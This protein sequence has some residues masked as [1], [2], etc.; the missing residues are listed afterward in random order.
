MSIN[1]VG[2]LG[3]T[4]E[5][6]VSQFYPD[7]RFPWFGS[8]RRSISGIGGHTTSNQISWNY[9]KILFSNKVNL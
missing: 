1:W 2:K 5:L 3:Q 9:P 7:I 8:M 4:D 6:S